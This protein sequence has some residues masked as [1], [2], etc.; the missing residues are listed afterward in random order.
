VELDEVTDDGEAEPEPA[1][2]AGGG[3]VGLAEAVKDVGQEGGVDAFASVGDADDDAAIGA[4][5]VNA[6]GA[7]G[8]RELDGVAEQVP[9]DL[10]EAVG[11]AGD[12]AGYL[13][14]ARLKGI[15]LLRSRL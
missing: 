1:V 11:I 2:R 3:G 10:L 7:A 6:D 14:G 13:N 8:G 9:D 15:C 5:D 12:S 4:G